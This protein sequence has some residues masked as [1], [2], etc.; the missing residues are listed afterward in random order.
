MTILETL[1]DIIP[2]QFIEEVRS[3]KKKLFDEVGSGGWNA[4]HFAVFYGKSEI[5][6]M[7][8]ERF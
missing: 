7:F 6:T 3:R 8:I 5:C 4:L 2:E 1:T